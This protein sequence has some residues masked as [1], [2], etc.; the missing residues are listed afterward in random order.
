MIKRQNSHTEETNQFKNITKASITKMESRMV[1]FDL[2]LRELEDD[3]KH[4]TSDIH[5]LLE[6]ASAHN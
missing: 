3:S 5:K 2:R 1:S 4:K 6:E